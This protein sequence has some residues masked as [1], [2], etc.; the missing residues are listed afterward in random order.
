MGSKVDPQV[1]FYLGPESS[2]TTRQVLRTIPASPRSLIVSLNQDPYLFR[3]NHG[4]DFEVSSE[5][6]TISL[7]GAQHVR[8]A[9]RMS[10]R[11]EVFSERIY[12]RILFKELPAPFCHADSAWELAVILSRLAV[13]R[14]AD[15]LV[16]LDFQDENAINVWEKSLPFSWKGRDKAIGFWLNT[17]G[18]ELR[19]LRIPAFEILS[20]SSKMEAAADGSSH[21]R[22][23]VICLPSSTS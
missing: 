10:W 8:I 12:D 15:V 1:I 9:D 20:Q 16:T 3:L 7:H 17:Q 22:P 23:P 19:Y 2:S 21:F 11:K 13:L 5:S 6:S 14:S 4:N 18:A